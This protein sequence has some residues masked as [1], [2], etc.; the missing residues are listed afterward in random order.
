MPGDLIEVDGRRIKVPDAAESAKQLVYVALNKPAGVVS[1][2]KDTHGRPTVLGLVSGAARGA[3]LY[4]VGRLDTDTT[5]LLLLTNDGDLTFRLTHP[6]YGVEKEYRVVVRGR[7]GEGAI[8]RLREGVELEDGLT[9]PAKVDYLSTLEGN[10]TLRIVIHEGRKRQI[11]LMLSAVGHPA[12]EL[13][14]ARFGPI[15][16]GTLEEGKWRYLAAHEVHALKKAV[17][18]PTPRVEAKGKQTSGQKAQTTGKRP[19]LT[20]RSEGAR[21]R[22]PSPTPDTR[23]P[24]LHHKGEQNAHGRQRPRDNKR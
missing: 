23:H 14:R 4:P 9:A 10:A 21:R 1:T 17:R 11:R 3:R 16:L 2:V 7:P 8:Q 6:R 20:G 5:G 22:L 19:E 24:T 15:E 18:L 12:L 13:K